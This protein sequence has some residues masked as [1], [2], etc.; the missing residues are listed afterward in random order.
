[1]RQFD[2]AIDL[3]R[4]AMEGSLRVLGLAH[5]LTE[6]AI[7]DYYHKMTTRRP[8]WE[9]A[10]KTVE[11]MFE[12][13]RREPRP[14]DKLFSTST[15]LLADSFSRLGQIEKAIALIDT[16]PANRFAL[17]V[18]EEVARCFYVH[19]HRDAALVQFQRVEALRPRLVPADDPYGLWIRTRLA[20]VLREHGR[21]GE[22]RPL[23]EQTV[24][25]ALRL[26]KAVSKRDRAIEEP[27]G[28]AEFL[29]KQWPGRAPG[30]SP[31]ERPPASF[32]IEVPFRAASPVADGRIA[33]GEYGPGIAVMFDDATNPGRLWT[34]GKSRPK[35]PDDLSAHIHTAYTDRSLFLAFQVR[36]QSL[37]YT[38]S[39][40]FPNDAVDVSVDG[41]H[42]AN[43]HTLVCFNGDYVF[44]QFG[45]REGFA[46]KAD[47]AGH[48]W[49]TSADFTNA[50]WKVGTSRTADGY[51]IEFEIPLA[52]IDTRDGPEYVPAAG[53]SEIRANFDF[54]DVDGQRLG[55]DG[56]DWGIFWTEDPDIAPGA[57]GEDF[58][59]VSLRLVPKPAG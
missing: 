44:D 29:L 12:Q 43:D 56:L 34:W 58:W 15:G 2:R 26:R 10:R 30:I 47:P 4:R 31:A 22:A 19:G 40:P 59:T 54:V 18:R 1:L 13:S 36:D 20:L 39:F 28:I 42:V 38:A 11:P 50:D 45:G 55:V 3:T 7:R 49:T 8:R 52:L 25:E 9:E 14:E 41:D 46:I 32:R 48:Q 37:L 16:L 27:R 17:G 57:S 24:A 53:G 6:E 35:S 5:P 23:L 51:I 33:P 21:F